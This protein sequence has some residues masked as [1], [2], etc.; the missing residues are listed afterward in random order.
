MLKQHNKPRKIILMIKKLIISDLGCILL[1]CVIYRTQIRRFWLQRQFLATFSLIIDEI[2]E[3][4]KEQKKI[5]NI[6]A[7]IQQKFQRSFLKLH[8]LQNIN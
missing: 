8:N 3:R 6:F 4:T 5:Q 1:F 7:S 2:K